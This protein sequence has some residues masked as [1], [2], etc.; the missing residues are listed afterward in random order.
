MRA[1]GGLPRLRRPP[2]YRVIQDCIAKGSTGRFRIVQFSVQKDHLHLVIEAADKQALSSGARGLAIRSARRLN[3]HLGRTG[4]VWGDRYHTR[5]MKTPTEVRR[6][7]VYVLMNIRKHSEEPCDG[8]D[9]CSSALWFDGFT[10]AIRPP[11]STG[12]PPVQSPQTW[13]ASRGWRLR[14]LI[15]PREY[16]KTL[17]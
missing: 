12:P 3:G 13:L 1:V 16:P 17:V 4:K 2:I 15:D 10:V 11:A 9:P 5:A 8:L 7:L 6:A 14:G